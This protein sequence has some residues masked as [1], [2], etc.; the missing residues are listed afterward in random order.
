MKYGTRYCFLPAAFEALLELL[1]RTPRSRRSPGFFISVEHVGIG[2]LR[3]DL[4]MAADVMRGQLL[5]VLRDA[6]GQVHADA[7]RRRAPS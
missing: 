5:H 1:G 3:G 6:A 4:E 2:V 7:A